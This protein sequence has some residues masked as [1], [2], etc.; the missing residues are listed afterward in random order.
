MDSKKIYEEVLRKEGKVYCVWT[1]KSISRY[2]VDHMVPFSVWKNNDLWNLLPSQPSTNNQKRHKIPSVE[3]IEKQQDLIIEY[4]ELIQRNRPER[5][6]KEVQI[7]LLGNHPF[8]NWHKMAIKQ[9]QKSCHYLISERGY[10]SW[11]I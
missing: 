7:T 4:W 1:G 6:Q 9:L 2:D 11:S 3:L 5:F 10:E 8:L